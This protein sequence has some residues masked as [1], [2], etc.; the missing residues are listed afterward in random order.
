MFLIV[1]DEHITDVGE[2]TDSDWICIGF[3]F[4]CAVKQ[5]DLRGGGILMRFGDPLYHAGTIP[6][7]HIN[8]IQ[9]HGD[10][11]YRVPL[12]KDASDREKNYARLLD[13]RNELRGRGGKDFLFPEIGA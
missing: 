1:P 9:P 4:S 13:H 2:L 12:A 8:I 11:E 10:A 7:I 6:H 3:L 5:F